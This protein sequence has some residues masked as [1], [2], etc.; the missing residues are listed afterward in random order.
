MAAQFTR[1]YQRFAKDLLRFK[2]ATDG[3]TLYMTHD[4]DEKTAPVPPR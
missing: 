1:K 4:T 2:G 3:W